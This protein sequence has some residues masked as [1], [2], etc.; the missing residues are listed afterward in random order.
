MAVHFKQ[1]SSIFLHWKLLLSLTFISS[2]VWT[3]VSP[4]P[5]FKEGLQW[6]H[7]SCY[8]GWS[9]IICLAWSLSIDF[10]RTLGWFWMYSKIQ[11][12]NWHYFILSLLHLNIYSYATQF[13]CIC[14]INIIRSFIYRAFMEH[15]LFLGTM[16]RTYV[17]I[18]SEYKIGSVVIFQKLPILKG[19]EI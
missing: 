7:S 17:M 12:T 6:P 15:P 9:H 16:P 13:V 1:N 8:V 4:I 19:A 10:Y 11:I 14:N 2:H 5:S 18:K 3:T